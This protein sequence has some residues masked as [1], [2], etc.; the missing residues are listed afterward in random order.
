MPLTDCLAAA[1]LSA[2]DAAKVQKGAGAGDDKAALAAANNLLSSIQKEVETTRSALGAPA[3]Q[4]LETPAVP[5]DDP[6]QATDVAD[7]AMDDHI[8]ELYQI[9]ATRVPT[10]KKVTVDPNE[11][12][13][14]GLDTLRASPKAYEKIVDE[15]STYPNIVPLKGKNAKSVDMR[16]ERFIAHVTDNL[17][18]LHDLMPANLRSR[19]KLWYDGGRR[20]IDRWVKEF[21]F[22]DA[23]TAA[24][25]AVFSPQT[26]WY[27][28]VSR[29]NRVL[30]F[31]TSKTQSQWTPEMQAR[32]DKILKNDAERAVVGR[33]YA[34]L[35]TNE[36]RAVWIRVYDEAHSNREY[37]VITPEG[38][39]V[40][41]R[42]TKTGQAS[43]LAWANYGQIVKALNVLENGSA[44]NISDQLGGEHKVR[45]FY[46]NLFEPNAAD[47]HVTIDTHAVAAALFSPLAGGSPAVVANLGGTGSDALTGLSGSYA[48]YAEAY[49]RAAASRGLL[50]REIQSITWEAVRGIFSPRFKSDAENVKAVE[51][52][53]KQHRSGAITQAQARDQILALAGGLRTPDWGGA[54]GSVKDEPGTITWGEI[55]AD[56]KSALQKPGWAVVTATTS[57]DPASAENNA[58]NDSL[59]QDLRA[60]GIQYRVVDGSWKGIDQGRSFMIL[61]DAKTAL[62]LGKR[63]NQES[64]L[65][66]AGWVYAD[67]SV[68]QATGEV[69]I[70][71][72]ARK[73]EGFTAFRGAEKQAFS[74]KLSD[75]KV[76]PVVE[77]NQ[78][79]AKGGL[80]RTVKE[81]VESGKPFR[82]IHWSRAED[83]EKIDPNFAG[84]S[85]GQEVAGYKTRGV[86]KRVFFGLLGRYAKEQNVVGTVPYETTVNPSEVYDIF[87]D[88]MEFRRQGLE[89][90]PKDWRKAQQHADNLARE[91]G[92]KWFY[93]SKE[94]P[95][96]PA[97]YSYEAVNVAPIAAKEAADLVRP[98]RVEPTAAEQQVYN[99]GQGGIRIAGQAELGNTFASRRRFF[100]ESRKNLALTDGAL[101]LAARDVEE[102][103]GAAYPT[104]VWRMP[105]GE[106]GA[107]DVLVAGGEGEPFYLKTG[108]ADI[109]DLDGDEK[110]SA[111]DVAELAE[112]KLTEGMPVRDA[113][114]KLSRKLGSPEAAAK[115]LNDVMGG[116]ISTA[117]FVGEDG[118]MR[119]T[120]NSVD[121]LID[122][123]TRGSPRGDRTFYQP[124]FHGTFA[125]FEG[126]MKITDGFAIHVGTRAA[127]RSRIK[128]IREAGNDAGRLPRMFEFDFTPRLTLEAE[129]VGL[130]NSAKSVLTGGLNG[131]LKRALISA[132]KVEAWRRIESRVLSAA[133]VTDEVPIISDA[134]RKKISSAKNKEYLSIVREELLAEGFDSVSYANR[135]EA[136]GSTSYA[137]LDPSVLRDQA[138][139]LLKQEGPSNSR[140]GSVTIT[141]EKYIVRFFN[142]DMTTLLHEFG[143]IF[144]EE[145]HTVATS[146]AASEQTIKDYETVKEWLGNTGEAITREQHEKWATHF[147]L[148]LLDGKAPSDVLR[149]PFASF[150]RWITNVYSRVVSAGKANGSLAVAGLAE[151]SGILPDLRPE[152]K[153]VFDRLLTLEPEARAAEITSEFHGLPPIEEESDAAVARRVR[154]QDLLD[155]ARR[156]LEDRLHARRSA[157]IA[158]K[159]K[160]WAA[161]AAT[162]LDNSRLYKLVDEIKKAPLDAGQIAQGYGE[163]ALRQLQKLGFVENPRK[164]G[165]DL[166]VLAINFGFPS[167]G[168]MVAA[169]RSY[170]PKEVAVREAVRLASD[171]AWKAYTAADAMADTPAYANALKASGD[172]IAQVLGKAPLDSARIKAEAVA[173]IEGMKVRQATRVDD[174]LGSMARLQRAEAAAS[175]KGDLAGALDANRKARVQL[176]MAKEARKLKERVIAIGERAEKLKKV[177]PGSVAYQY[178]A[179]A[180]ALAARYELIDPVS[181]QDR[182]SVRALIQAAQDPTS[183]L[184]EPSMDVLAAFPDW[185][186][187]EQNAGSY[188]DMSIGD[189]QAVD[190]LSRFLEQRGRQIVKDQILDGKITL[191]KAVADIIVTVAKRGDKKVFAEGSIAARISGMVDAYLSGLNI[192]LFRVRAMDGFT[193]GSQ[194]AGPSERL[195]WDPLHRG[196]GKVRELHSSVHKMIE[197]ALKHLRQRMLSMPKFIETGL[198]VTEEMKR[199]GRDGYTFENVVVAALNMGNDYNKTALLD[200][201]QLNNELQ[202]NQLTAVLTEADWRA[203]QSIWDAINTLKEPL[204]ATFERR[205]GFPM[206]TVEANPLTV[207]TAEGLDITLPG[208]Y[209]PVKFDKKL[210]DTAAERSEAEDL[211]AAAGALFPVV[212]TKSG[213]TKTRKGTGGQPLLLTMSGLEGH[214]KDTAQYIGLS[215]AV[216]DVYR[217]ARH[218]AFKR[219]FVQKF[220]NDAY[221][222]I[223]RLLADIGMP[224]AGGQEKMDQALGWLRGG[225]TAWTLGLNIGTAVKQTNAV[226]NYASE[227]GLG[228]VALGG[229]AVAQMGYRQAVAQM[230]ALSP[231]MAERWVTAD[232]EISD[233]IKGIKW[234]SSPKLSAV[235]QAMFLP[236]QVMDRATVLPLWWGSYVKRLNAGATEAEAA[237]G[238]DKAIAASVPGAPRGLDQAAFLR[239]KRGWMRLLTSFSTFTFHWG[240]RQRFYYEGLQAGSV[241]P[242]EFGYHFVVEGLGAPIGTLMLMAFLWGTFP[243]ETDKERDKVMLEWGLDLATY[244]LSGLPLVREV[245]NA[246]SRYAT[247]GRAPDFGS[248]IPTFDG[249]D[250]A[251]KFSN[252]LVDLAKEMGDGPANSEKPV[253]ALKALADLVSFGARIPASKV[254]EKMMEG[255]RQLEAFPNDDAALE[256]LNDAFTVLVPN[257]A[258]R[259]KK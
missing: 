155:D 237:L 254:L 75:T 5:E 8:R 151:T 205:M 150:R 191:E 2:A 206:G 122:P 161:Q 245:A 165:A 149:R 132:G 255:W 175:L 186:L 37:P 163:K 222:S 40:A 17:L 67:G 78:P 101:A 249:I 159:R 102:L 124:V 92:F 33:A 11:V 216:V 243:P 73:Q 115:K 198:P 106:G 258:N 217:I 225:A 59:A 257:P 41:A 194:E 90:F 158:S 12:L 61:A 24:V 167:A 219:I 68:Q 23:Q 184:Y 221:S 107:E 53:W 136:K 242:A 232:R 86:K 99:Y 44:K 172:Y 147:E 253:K 52:I 187:D 211:K 4:D 34:D 64:V 110:L 240:N 49:R 121:Q 70:G 25:I 13:V 116:F 57:G 160:E 174:F 193:N 112:F 171:E 146:G 42:R 204:A 7:A 28:N 66:S 189:L 125:K 142:G 19:A 48:L 152:V 179:N 233:A 29:A 45:N 228:A 213:M 196:S 80:P 58:A 30:D 113:F 16:A 108:K 47:G 85:G 251:I 144:L 181:P 247:S 38:D 127:A 60:A 235:Q 79:K 197:P 173:R 212:G 230:Q 69:F 119:A 94:G 15:V 71:A 236:I 229:K 248:A 164:A 22:T 96:F 210:S 170:V 190:N 241:S 111:E 143:H 148:Y 1:N 214:L 231:F 35:K 185:V 218:P 134:F 10:S 195:M 9:Q 133:G 168:D 128:H 153:A 114:K 220:G 141:D 36:E 76:G 183:A 63:F 154:H 244:Q 98:A 89:K 88:P 55:D 201:L 27:A 103:K 95:W 178:H 176:A 6:V 207:R 199:L 82:L 203:V 256:W 83:I 246:T 239:D 192:W 39:F 32:A 87:A 93:S 50:A 117:V 26:D 250:L 84:A 169:L 145:L 31:V 226:F 65:T 81:A 100:Q 215:E 209:Y 51:E 109:L 130:W 3:P 62:E 223:R 72:E 162:A 137:V 259:G 157:I 138:V 21:G 56:L 224:E 129:D 54:V 18:W 238:A 156:D 14:V 126:S 182:L 118:L 140:R 188:L 234:A 202:L 252:S 135:F 200:G 139:K 123:E 105:R 177:K 74:L 91:A 180:L 104:T 43:T 20:I 46:N 97:L 120:T 77:L 131:G 166:D 208:G 227:E